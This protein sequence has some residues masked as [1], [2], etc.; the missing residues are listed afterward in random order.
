MKFKVKKRWIWIIVAVLVVA[1]AI[2]GFT[3]SK[4]K[5]NDQQVKTV[6]AE[7]KDIV[8]KALAVGAVEPDVEVAVKSKVSGVVRKLFVDVG[9]FVKSGDLLLEVKPDPTP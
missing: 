7:K 4:G 3:S 8:D 6:K 1:L 5:N 9:D 2:V